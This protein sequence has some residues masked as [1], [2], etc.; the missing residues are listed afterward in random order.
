MGPASAGQKPG[1][2]GPPGSCLPSRKPIN[3]RVYASSFWALVYRESSFLSPSSPEVG[4]GRCLLKL[5]E[6]MEIKAALGD[7]GQPCSQPLVGTLFLKSELDKFKILGN[8]LGGWR[9]S[10]CFRKD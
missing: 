9:T 4:G 8:E 3:I 10:G 6:A 1:A 5:G 7:L 2:S